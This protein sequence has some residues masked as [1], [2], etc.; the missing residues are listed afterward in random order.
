MARYN[1]SKRKYPVRKKK[2][3]WY[4]KKYST[5]EL[6]KKAWV[7]TRYL[8]GL[9]N[10]EMLHI[11]TNFAGSAITGSGFVQHLTN[12]AQNDTISGRTGNSILVRNL[13]YRLKFE[14]S[15]SVSLDTS[16]TMI[17]FID[18]QQIS[19]SNPS[20][21]D[22][23][24]TASPQSLLNLNNAGRFKILQRKSITLTPATGGKPAVEY[25]KTLNLYNHVRYNGTGSTDQQKNAIYMLFVSS[26]ATNYPGLT[27]SVRIGYHDN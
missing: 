18:T 22:V 27:G 23:L 11:D 26:E 19:D 3:S 13:T 1:Y 5:M 10:S 12:I 14:I 24:T 21:T 20:V 2:V 4:D 25:S 16:I 7:A 15:A 9:V 6:A 17:I 8:R